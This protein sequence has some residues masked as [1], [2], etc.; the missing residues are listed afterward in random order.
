MRIYQMT[1]TFGKLEHQTLTLQPGLNVI[2]APNEWGKSTWCAFLV[3]MLYGLDT[4]A[5]TTKTN[6]ADKE[7]Y[8]PWSGAP[9]EGRI[10]LN[11][12]GRDITIERRSKRR[13]PMGEFQ[14]YETETGLPVTELTGE[15]CGLM[16]LGVE[17]S[18]FRRAGFIR[19]SDLPVTQD[20][21]FRRRLNDLVTTGDESGNAD[22]L[23]Q[24]LKELKNQCRY[25]R[26][27]KLPQAEA[28]REELEQKIA[29][30]ES[31]DAQCKKLRLRIDEVKNWIGQLTNHRQALDYAANQENARRVA[32]ARDTLEQ[33]EALLRKQETVCANHPG[34]EEAQQK[35]IQLR[36]LRDQLASAWA[37]REKLP[38][39]P[40]KPEAPVPF[41]GM[42]PEEAMKM[43]REDAK[44]Y[45][46]L[47][48][49]AVA[50]MLVVMGVFGLI[51]TGVLVFL[52]A[53][54][55]A[56]VA[57][58]GALAAFVWGILEHS[59]IRKKIT[60]LEEKYGNRNHKQW[61]S[62]LKEYAQALAEY[63]SQWQQY[64]KMSSE[65]ESRMAALQKKRTL[66]CREQEPE[67]ALIAC[68]AAVNA[69]AELDRLRRD[70][71]L[72]RNHYE[73]LR[74][75]VKHVAK[76][77]QPDHLTYSAEDTARL[78]A[79]CTTEQ[80]RLQNRM[81]QYQGRM[82]ALGD[83]AELL[84]R[85]ERKKKRIDRL[86]QTYEALTLAQ[87]TLAQ[88]RLEL[89]RRFAPRI[90]KRA[91]IMLA[92]MTGGRYQT[93]TMGE[94]LSLRARTEAEDTLRDVI[95]RSDGTMDQIYLALRLAVSEELTPGTP[96]VLDDV[97]V[98]FDDQRMKEA[99]RVL[100][101]L[102]KNRQVIL[103]SCQNREK[104]V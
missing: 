20:E 61:G 48:G 66:L 60:A 83:K 71:A 13:T 15:N 85:L 77:S 95:W 3:A 87:E 68:T 28:E 102:A 43:A 91:Q 59:A 40:Q 36:Q 79:D 16:L 29:E 101:G 23:A 65:L 100:E 22:R 90:T 56:L 94:D 53:Y 46:E 14:A 18:V 96:L 27:G 21:A 98:R 76:P 1:A 78:L 67:T 63:Q 88:A 9:M 62:G 84:A 7:R 89:Q 19:H 45:A 35:Q 44:V 93:V 75:M 30:I 52:K 54:L 6:L 39:Q 50:K 58:L 10:D 8:A 17:E 104:Q 32:Q 73:T 64:Q 34:R 99:V 31:L 86:E 82:E 33:A 55:F 74:V 81:G 12:D 4:R 80:Q 11:W 37:D 97:L 38:Q 51:A 42:D 47:K 92:Q 2:T 57:G 72:A 5:K 41:D 24:S 69:W 103:F 26:T 70:A 49:T 25:N